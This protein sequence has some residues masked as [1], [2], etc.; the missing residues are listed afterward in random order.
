MISCIR[1]GPGACPA[2]QGP[3][4]SADRETF[5]AGP[6]RAGSTDLEAQPPKQALV[7]TYNSGTCLAITEST[8]AW[9]ALS[10]AGRQLV[11]VCRPCLFAVRRWLTGWQ[12][13]VRYTKED[14]YGDWAY[15][16]TD[17]STTSAMKVT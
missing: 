10:N 1:V 11:V 5:S 13:V 16:L 14:V 12:L 2:R 4:L 3:R 17:G 15:C 7:I 6:L 9:Q 8:D